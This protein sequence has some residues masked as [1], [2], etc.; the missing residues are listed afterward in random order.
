MSQ[1]LQVLPSKSGTGLTEISMKQEKKL[2][3]GKKSF[4]KKIKLKA[5]KAYP[6]TF[7]YQ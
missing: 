7:H 2:A 4:S 5:A 1:T 6:H 3:E